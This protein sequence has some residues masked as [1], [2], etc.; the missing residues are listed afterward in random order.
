M[1]AVSSPATP[2]DVRT[3]QEFKGLKVR[4]PGGVVATIVTNLGGQATT[5]APSETY[6]ALQRGTLDGVASSTKDMDTFKWTDVGKY[7]QPLGVPLG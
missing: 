5:I 2:K 3:L 7:F 6:E 4:V 1:S